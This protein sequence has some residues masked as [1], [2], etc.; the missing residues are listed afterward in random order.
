LHEQRT[1]ALGDGKRRYRYTCYR[2]CDR[3]TERYLPE[4]ALLLDAHVSIEKVVAEEWSSYLLKYATEPNPTSTLHL[5][6][7][8]MLSLGFQ[9]ENVYSRAVAR[10]ATTQLTSRV[11]LHFLYWLHP[12]SAHHAL[13]NT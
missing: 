11:S 7:P 6:E 5:T 8:E 12:L 13:S 4:L 9:H 2:E 1:P 3:W 10:F